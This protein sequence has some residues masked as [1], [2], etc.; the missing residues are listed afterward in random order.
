[1]K[2]RIKNRFLTVDAREKTVLS[3]AVA[4]HTVAHITQIWGDRLRLI[5]LCVSRLVPHG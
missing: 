3:K 4:V 2:S 1:M 5:S